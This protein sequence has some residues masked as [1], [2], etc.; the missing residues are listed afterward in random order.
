MDIFMKEIH[1][2]G[3]INTKNIVIQKKKRLSSKDKIKISKKN[4]FFYWI[5]GK[6]T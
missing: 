3:N 4:Y 6:F 5:L 2:F 1:Q